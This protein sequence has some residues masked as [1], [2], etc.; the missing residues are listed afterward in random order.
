[1]IVSPEAGGQA[2]GL[3][4]KSSGT[5]L[6]T[7]VGLLRDAFSHTE[8]PPGIKESRARGRFGLFNRP[9]DAVWQTENGNPV[10][11]LHYEAPDILPAGASI[12]KTVQFE[13][14]TALRVDYR[15]ALHM[16]TGDA[17]AASSSSVQSFI[18]LNSFPALAQLGE[19]TRFCW[20]AGPDAGKHGGADKTEDPAESSDHC[21]DF[22]PGG[23]TIK[24]PASTTRVEVRT[25]DWPGIAIEWE[26]TNV[27]AQMTIEPK[28]F[29]VLFR[30]A[31]PPLTPG[32]DEIE[33]TMRFRTLGVL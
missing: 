25:P 33:Y 29:S 8:N 22:K 5:N 9:Y 23:E 24:V 7:S 2:I 32:A 3:V 18:G 31:F 21:E 11:T 27:C 17:G 16:D 13:G 4:E 10:L 1:M 19:T 6:T 28:N 15:I 12:K 26:C 30:L 14:T 20:A